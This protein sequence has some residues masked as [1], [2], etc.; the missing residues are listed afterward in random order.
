MALKTNVRNFSVRVNRKRTVSL[1]FKPVVLS[2]DYRRRTSGS[3][4]GARKPYCGLKDFYAAVVHA[5][6]LTAVRWEK[7]LLRVVHGSE[8]GSVRGEGFLP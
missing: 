1:I 8:D 6:V 5:D 2:V 3:L 4:F 7:T